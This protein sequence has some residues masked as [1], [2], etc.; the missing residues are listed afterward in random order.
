MKNPLSKAHQKGERSR[1]DIAQIENKIPKK[2]TSQEFLNS[3]NTQTPSGLLRNLKSDFMFGI[4]TY[5]GNQPFIILKVSDFKNGF[6]G[7]L[8]WE[9]TLFD[10]MYQIFNISI[11]DE[12]KN[13]FS[14]T[15]EDK[16]L[17]NKDARVLYDS[18]GTPALFYLFLDETT[19]LIAKDRDAVREVMTRIKI[20]K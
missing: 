4:H 7:M 17:E 10:D 8:A 5:D 3:I 1:R 2:I 11:Q 15:F 19:I 13:L 6:A 14:R 12:N 16:V 20:A 18:S 9:R